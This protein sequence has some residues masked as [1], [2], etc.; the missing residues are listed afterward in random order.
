MAR[1]PMITR[2]I[3]ITKV[4]VM[5]LDIEKCEPFN[6]EVI[7]PRQYKDDK[8]LFKAVETAIN[9]GNIKAVHIVDKTECEKMYGMYETV[10][11][12]AADELDP[13]TRRPVVTESTEEK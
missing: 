11:I 8:K 13:V 4:N 7:L 2:T 9:D 6:K 5:C 1:T 3:T 12:S 10:F